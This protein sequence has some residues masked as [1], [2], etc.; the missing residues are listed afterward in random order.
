MSSL[1]LCLQCSDAL[2]DSQF[3]IAVDMND[4]PLI[5]NAVCSWSRRPSESVEYVYSIANWVDSI[6]VTIRD[7]ET[8]PY[9]TLPAR[10]K[11]VP[12]NTVDPQTF[13]TTLK[14][15][16]QFDSQICET[17]I[18]VEVNDA[19]RGTVEHHVFSE[20]EESS[21]PAAGVRPQRRVSGVLITGEGELTVD[22]SGFVDDGVDTDSDVFSEHSLEDWAGTK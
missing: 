3:T 9:S 22:D 8:G 16:K 15:Y 21:H 20:E 17:F 7:P 10:V 4:H 5:R 19:M 18:A 2:C 14:F 11:L 13:R 1:S 12:P 6:T